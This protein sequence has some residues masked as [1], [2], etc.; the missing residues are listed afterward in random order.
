MADFV[1]TTLNDE[2]DS[3]ATVGSPGGDGLSLREAIALANDSAG[4]DNITFAADL[5]GTIQ[6][7]GGEL[8]VTDDLLISGDGKITISGDV[9]GNDAPDSDGL[10]DVFAS[11]TAELADNTRIFGVLTPAGGYFGVDG[12]TLTG[13]YL[14][15]GH[16]STLDGGSGAIRVLYN[17]DLSITNSLIAGNGSSDPGTGGAIFAR[18]DLT[19]TGLSL[20][21]I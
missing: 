6:L 15:D 18:G 1:V 17:T 14:Q 19:I 2:N 8:F 21:H 5:E 3:G 9:A 13:G 16:G 20:I 12:L 4:R 10:T 11:T 7:T